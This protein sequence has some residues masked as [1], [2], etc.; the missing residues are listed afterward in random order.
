MLCCHLI[1]SK[2]KINGD[3]NSH[4]LFC[5]LRQLHAFPLSF[6]GFTELSVSFVT[7][8]SDFFGLGFTTLS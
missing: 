3:S 6:V 7:H 5:T 1:S 8:Q 4:T 2:F